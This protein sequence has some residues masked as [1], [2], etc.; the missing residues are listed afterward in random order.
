[1]PPTLPVARLTG[2]LLILSPY[3]F[4]IIYAQDNYT[5]TYGAD[6]PVRDDNP[7]PEAPVPSESRESAEGL[8]FHCT[9][10]RVS[11]LCDCGVL[12]CI[13]RVYGV[14]MDAI[15]KIAGE[16]IIRAAYL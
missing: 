10:V 8:L 16:R 12:L 2:R 4:K 5:D 15:V 14:V 3:S 9:L 11:V 7:Y 6:A 1:M 13:L